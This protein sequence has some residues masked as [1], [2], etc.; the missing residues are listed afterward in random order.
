ME[1]K[2]VTIQKKLLEVPFDELKLTGT[3]RLSTTIDAETV[4][5]VE[6]R[7]SRPS[8]GGYKLA[9]RRNRN[10]QPVICFGC[11]EFTFEKV[12]QLLDE[13]N[14]PDLN[15]NIEKEGLKNIKSN[16]LKKVKVVEESENFFITTSYSNSAQHTAYPKKW[17]K[18]DTYLVSNRLLEKVNGTCFT[19]NGHFVY[20]SEARMYA[21]LMYMNALCNAVKDYFNQEDL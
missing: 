13:F 19:V 10:G 4:Q 21:L 1:I 7:Y 3:F 20:T 11:K 12:K 5:E 18:K 14:N 9:V 8:A 16:T 15:K 2:T 6:V 17:Y